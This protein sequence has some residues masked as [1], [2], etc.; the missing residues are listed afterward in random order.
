M[1]CVSLNFLTTLFYDRHLRETPK[2]ISYRSKI[3]SGMQQLETLRDLQ[4]ELTDLEV[5]N[6]LFLDADNNRLSVKFRSGF[7]FRIEQILR[8]YPNINFTARK[9]GDQQTKSYIGFE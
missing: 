2:Y 4:S 7:D 8:E 5:V 3:L 1:E 6:E 9:E